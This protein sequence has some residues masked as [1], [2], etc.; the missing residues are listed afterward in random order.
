[1]L[2]ECR[3]GR[4]LWDQILIQIFSGLAGDHL[5]PHEVL[6]LMRTVSWGSLRFRFRNLEANKKK[7]LAGLVA[8][9]QDTWD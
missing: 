3:T 4:C 9:S 7:K 2:S 8:L 5:V 1:M 6:L